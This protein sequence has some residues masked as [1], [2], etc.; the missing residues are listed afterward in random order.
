MGIMVS[1]MPCL[2]YPWKTAAG[3]TV[4]AEWAQVL[5][6]ISGKKIKSLAPTGV[7]SLNCPVLSESSHQ[8]CYHSPSFTIYA[9][10]QY[11]DTSRYE[12]TLHKLH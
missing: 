7:Q 4:E 9:V 2:L 6:W 5:I 11:H 12:A 3:P 1:V 10:H 8:L